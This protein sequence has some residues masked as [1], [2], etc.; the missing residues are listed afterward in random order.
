MLIANPIYDTAFKRLME[1]QNIAKF[2]IGTLI[3]QE[4]VSLDVKPQEYTHKKSK[5]TIIMPDTEYDYAGI[6]VFRVDFVAVIKTKTGVHKKILVEVQK[7]WDIDDIMRFRQ[8]LGEHYARKDTVD[9]T[10]QVLPITSIYI[11]DFLLPEIESPCIKVQRG[12]F[13]LTN[14]HKALDCEPSP[15]IEKLTHDS[16]VV[17][18]RRIKNV[19]MQDKLSQLLSIFEQDKFIINKEYIKDYTYKATDATVLQMVEE[20]CFVVSDDDNRKELANEREFMRTMDAVFGKQSK[21]LAEQRQVIAEQNKK[22]ADRKKKNAEQKKELADRKKELTDRKKE[23][24][25]QKKELTE[26]KK[27][28]AQKDAELAQKNAELEHYKKLFEENQNQK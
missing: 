9:G 26:Q 5:K 21:K 25:D 15:F 27:K 22:L 20:L 17:Q 12:Y 6:S 1:N 18:V 2:F 28:N 4:V 7:S 14:N 8:Y 24:A 19:R 16:Y 10:E 3:E 23:L 11:L 13:D